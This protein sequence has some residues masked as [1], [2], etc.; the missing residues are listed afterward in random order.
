MVE[1]GTFDGQLDLLNI[2]FVKVSHNMVVNKASFLVHGRELV[3]M[4]DFV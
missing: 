1:Y 4:I 3:P 2:E